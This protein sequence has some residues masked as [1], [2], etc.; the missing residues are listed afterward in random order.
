MRSTGAQRKT[1]APRGEDAQTPAESAEGTAEARPRV[2]ERTCVGCRAVAP[3]SELARLVEGP[4]GAVAVDVRS[5]SGGRGAWVH[6]S[7]KCI[8]QAVKRRAAERS[9]GLNPAQGQD[10]ARVLAEVAQALARKV[11]SLL[12]AGR[13]GGH[14]VVG[15]EPTED[16]LRAGGVSL[17][18]LAKD[19]GATARSLS[20]GTKV[21]SAEWATRDALGKIFGRQEVAV[22][23]VTRAELAAEVVATIER[24]AGLEG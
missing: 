17:L 15:V 19:A 13:R 4:G 3:P 14:V 11:T 12:T 10:A 22:V 23:A 18:L 1:G 20:E 7:R 16:A 2:T 6:A 24:L 5:R 21:R 9:L 8:E